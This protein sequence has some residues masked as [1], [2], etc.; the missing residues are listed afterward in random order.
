M[1]LNFLTLIDPIIYSMTQGEYVN[2][3]DVLNQAGWNIWFYRGP[4]DN[5]TTPR[6][7]SHPQDS[8]RIDPWLNAVTTIA[9]ATSREDSYSQAILK[10]HYFSTLDH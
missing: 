5:Y 2:T 9:P 8:I 4:Y 3:T 6:T 10:F 1:D 7:T